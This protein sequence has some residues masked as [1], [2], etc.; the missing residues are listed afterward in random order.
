MTLVFEKNGNF[1]AENYQRSQKI[2]I[3]TSIPDR[4][5][6][7]LQ[8]SRKWSWSFRRGRGK[9]LP[10]S[11]PS[12]PLPS[13]RRST[14]TASRLPRRKR[15][16]GGREAETCWHLLPGIH[17][18]RGLLGGQRPLVPLLLLGPPFFPIILFLSITLLTRMTGISLHTQKP[19]TSQSHGSST[20]MGL[21]DW[22]RI[23]IDFKV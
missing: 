21:C 20:A 17:L 11:Q 4:C 3:I 14:A 18:A 9:P 23:K 16:P 10:A 5:T 1:F 19:L 6:I 8:T 2:M 13:Y 7:L 15:P 12:N 22:C